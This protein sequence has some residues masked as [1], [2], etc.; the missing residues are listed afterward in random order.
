MKKILSAEQAK[1]DFYKIMESVNNNSTVIEI[2]GGKEENSAVL[3][4]AKYYHAIQE[5][6][7]LINDGTW[8]KIREI[9]KDDSEFIDITDGIDWDEI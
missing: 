9:E 1:K 5:T 8:D 3:I 2:N 7:Y 6:L 4:S